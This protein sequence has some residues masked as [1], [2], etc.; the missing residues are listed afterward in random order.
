MCESNAYLD[1][2]NEEVLIMESVDAMEPDGQHGW[3]LVDLFGDQKTVKYRIKRMNL[4][5]HRIIFEA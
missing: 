5:E 4:V 1:T 2:G 3:R